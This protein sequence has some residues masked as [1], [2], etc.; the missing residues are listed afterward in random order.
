MSYDGQ[1]QSKILNIDS[2]LGGLFDNSHFGLMN[3]TKIPSLEA[4]E[5]AFKWVHTLAGLK[6]NP[7]ASVNKED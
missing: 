7:K 6:I 2:L 5:R 3:S 4:N 1:N